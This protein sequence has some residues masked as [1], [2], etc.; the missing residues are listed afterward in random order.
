MPRGKRSVQSD[1]AKPTQSKA[2]PP[3]SKVA[4]PPSNVTPSKAAPPLSK[5]APPPS[6]VTPKAASVAKSQP[7]SKVGSVDRAPRGTDEQSSRSFVEKRRTAAVRSV[8]QPAGRREM[9]HD[10]DTE[11]E[12]EGR[13]IETRAAE[14]PNKQPTPSNGHRHPPDSP[15]P[16]ISPECA[17]TTVQ[18]TQPDTPPIE[19]RTD[20]GKAKAPRKQPGA[21]ESIKK[22]AESAKAPARKNVAASGKQSHATKTFRKPPNPPGK[23]HTEAK[24]TKKPLALRKKPVGLSSNRDPSLSP[25]RAGLRDISNNQLDTSG[26]RRVFN[27]SAGPRSKGGKVGS[28]K[29]I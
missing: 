10:R 26:Q 15:S 17:W 13:A 21:T 29:Y 20:A 4:P 6:K 5:A 19:V 25:V 3:T 2:A 9:E 23:K 18:E 14:K 11:E 28:R 7:K 22:Q 8:R 24:T 12:E 1:N 16:P 27:L